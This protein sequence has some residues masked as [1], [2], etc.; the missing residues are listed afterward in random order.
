[1]S[2]ISTTPSSEAYHIEQYVIPAPNQTWERRQAQLA[3]LDP[4]AVRIK[5]M[6]AGLCHSDLHLWQG[7]YDIGRGQTYNFQDRPGHEYPIVPGHEIAGQVCELGS[8][9]TPEDG[10]AVGDHV[11]VYPFIGCGECPQC[12]HKRDN[13][14]EKPLQRVLGF[15][16]PGGFSTHTTVPDPR[17]VLKVPVGLDLRTVAV[18]TCSGLTAFSAVQESRSA[19]A[20]SSSVR[21]RARLLVVGCGGLGQWAIRLATAILPVAKLDVYAADCREEQLETART[22]GAMATVHWAQG[23]SADEV[24]ERTLSVCGDRV[25]VVIDFVGSSQTTSHSLGVLQQGGTLLV[26]GLYGGAL[27]HPLPLLPLRCHRIIGLHA[28]ST[29]ALAELLALIH[30]NNIKSPPMELFNWHQLNSAVVKLSQAKIHGRAVIEV[31]P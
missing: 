19:L 24:K 4:R 11:A 16:R 12:L 28:G 6:Y 23:L 3:P 18:A 8:A 25:D 1:M 29:A 9:V 14:C 27:E 13:F 26:V 31:L 17:F 30:E 20:L 10:L 7:G 15:Q 2:N 5:V 21:G 22:C